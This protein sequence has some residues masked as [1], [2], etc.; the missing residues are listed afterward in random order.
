MAAPQK[1]LEDKYTP[2][3]YLA[4]ERASETKHEYLD[5]HIFV[6]AECEP[7]HNQICFNT[8]GALGIQLKGTCCVGYMSGQKIRTDP[9]DL[10][11]I[12]I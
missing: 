9:M 1:K 5:G 10:F 2:E 4:F 12:L 6:R 8:I 7:L 3:E 11:H